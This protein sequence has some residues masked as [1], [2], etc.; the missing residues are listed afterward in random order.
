MFDCGKADSQMAPITPNTPWFA[1]R[2][3]P[4]SEK[5]VSLSL[6]SKGYEEFL[7]VLQTR[8]RWSDRYKNI[9]V[10][11]FP[12]YLFCR[13]DPSWRLPILS[14]PGVMH[15]VGVGPAPVPI[16]EEEI[17]SLKFAVASRLHLEHRPFLNAGQQVRIEN[18]P[19]RGA[20]GIVV[21]SGEDPEKLVVS[22]SLLQRSVAVEIERGWAC[23]S[24]SKVANHCSPY[25]S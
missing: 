3:K 23:P 18:G 10:P 11:L 25:F 4:N 1:L 19:L 22:I 20:L 21:S 14:T 17:E 2:V 13:F 8:R 16:P 24:S 7:P 5:V 6:R 9:E 12:G 15:L